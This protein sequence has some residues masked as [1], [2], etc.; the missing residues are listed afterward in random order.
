MKQIHQIFIDNDITGENLLE[1]TNATLEKEL[2]VTSWGLRN[3][4]LKII[5]SLKH[6]PD[7]SRLV[8]ASPASSAR[9]DSDLNET[10][11]PAESCR[12]HLEFSSRQAE[13]DFTSARLLTSLFDCDQTPEIRDTQR[14]VA[15]CTYFVKRLLFHILN[16]FPQKDRENLLN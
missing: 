11:Q 12:L 14:I 8:P 1:L 2:G 7:Q 6:G 9:A 13:V 16:V 15:I 10:Q 3:K 5:D 4:I